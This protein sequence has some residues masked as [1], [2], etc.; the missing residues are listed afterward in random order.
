MA[1]APVHKVRAGRSPAFQDLGTPLDGLAVPRYP[2]V[3]CRMFSALKQ[4]LGRAWR[5]PDESFDVDS[6][7]RVPLAAVMNM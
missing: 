1:S 7:P 4:A 6:Y 2:S 3:Q 5:V